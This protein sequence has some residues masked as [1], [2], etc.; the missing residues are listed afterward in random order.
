MCESKVIIIEGGKR[1]IVMDAAANIKV[2]GATIV[3]TDITGESV[4]VKN[5]RVSE[6]NLLRHEILLERSR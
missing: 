1:E 4:E 5:V 3:C 2:D 6:M